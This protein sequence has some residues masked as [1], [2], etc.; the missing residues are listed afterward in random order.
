VH[1]R[2]VE[3]LLTPSVMVSQSVDYTPVSRLG[4]GLT[5]R[6]V[7]R[8]YLDNTND[9]AL[10]A[11][12]FFLADANVAYRITPRVRLSLQVNN[13]FDA[14]RVYPSGYSYR[15]FAGDVPSGDAYYFP[16]ATR[17]AVVLLDFGF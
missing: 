14:E 17:H 8:S 2:D 13:L 7:G 12:A 10:D 16:Q 9:Q 1:Y 3:P 4:L 6:Y 11:P 5:A 15:Y